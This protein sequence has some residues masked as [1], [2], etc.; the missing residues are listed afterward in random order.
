[1]K[2][3]RASDTSFLHTDIIDFQK[4]RKFAIII[5]ILSFIFLV[6]FYILF[7]LI[8]RAAGINTTGDFLYHFKSLRYLPFT[9]NIIF[10]AGLVIILS[11]HELIHG[12][13]FFLFTK[14]KPLIGFKSVYAYAASPDWYI[15]KKYFLII[16]LSPIIIMTITGFVLMLVVPAGYSSMIFLLVTVNAAGSIGDIWVSIILSRKPSETYVNDTG[17]SA[18]ISYN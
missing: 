12:F 18:K 4:N 7:D 10:L 3:L 6:I 9:A 8:T 13:F 14:E 1:M 5:N 16:T 2:V 15:R 11:V 17:L